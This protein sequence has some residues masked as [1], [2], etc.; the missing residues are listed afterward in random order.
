MLARKTAV[1]QIFKTL[2]RA[3]QPGAGHG[4]DAQPS[5]SFPAAEAFFNAML[6]P[7]AKVARKRCGRGVTLLNRMNLSHAKM[8]IPPIQ[9][10]TKML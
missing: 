9:S 4:R 1:V 7:T 10:D 6:K 3:R 2:R 5:G 8:G